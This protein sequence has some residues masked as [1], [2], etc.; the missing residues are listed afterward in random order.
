MYVYSY[1]YT[2]GISVLWLQTVLQSNSRC[3]W[4]WQSSEL[5]DTLRGHDRVSLG[6]DLEAV[7]ERFWRFT[8]RPQSHK[9]GDT[10]GGRDGASL[11]MHL[12]AEIERVWRY[13]LGVHDGATLEAAMERVWRPLSSEFV[14]A[15]GGHNRAISEIQLEAVIERVWW[16][17]WRPWSSECGDILWGAMIVR[18]WRP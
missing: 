1:P 7:I 16:C 4:K 3:T 9:F 6:K 5:S 12:E 11:E 18:T 15:P 10:L 14:D 2:H 17:S 8:W 13:A